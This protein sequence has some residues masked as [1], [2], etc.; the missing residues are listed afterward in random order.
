MSTEIWVAIGLVM[1]IEGLL[2]AI[3]PRG[4][5]NAV[6]MLSKQNDRVLRNFG[7]FLIAIGATIVFL[8]K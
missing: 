2:P 7:L 3:N 6:E 8:V 1:I 5:R 4:Y